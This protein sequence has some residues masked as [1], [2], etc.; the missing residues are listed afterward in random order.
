[1]TTPLN[2]SGCRY[3][4]AVKKAGRS[5]TTPTT[6]RWRSTLRLAS[7]TACGLTLLPGRTLLI[8]YGGTPF[9]EATPFASEM[10]PFKRGGLSSEIEIKT[11]MFRFKN[12]SSCGRADSVLNGFTPHRSQVQDPVGAVLSTELPTDDRHQVERSLVCVEGRGRISR[13]GLTQDIKMG[14]CVTSV[15]YHINR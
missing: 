5:S 13:S 1:M 14:S 3:W 12:G 4:S 9:C 10:W 11:F 8:T 7:D 15:T 2:M 6:S